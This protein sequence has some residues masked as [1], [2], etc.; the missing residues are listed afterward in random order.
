MSRFFAIGTFLLLFMSITTIHSHA[1]ANHQKQV[2]IIIDD[3]GGNVKGVNSFLSGDIPITA[4]VM[5]FQKYSTEQAQRA[6]EAGLEVIIHLP[7]EPKKGKASWLGPKGIKSGLSDHEIRSRVQQAIAD[8]PHAKGLNNH[9][10]SKIVEN[11]RIM[12][13]ILEVVKE[14]GLYVIDS[15]TSSASVIPKLA[16]ELGIPHATRHIF[17]DDTFSSRQHVNKQMTSLLKMAEKQ[18]KAIG[19]GHVGVKGQETFAGIS[20]ALPQFEQKNIEIVPASHL[21]DTEIDIDFEHF[22]N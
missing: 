8:V 12:R 11:E 3:F 13:I 20:L 22:W 4:A 6:H 2:A 15:G 21:L 10:G 18:K 14:H 9:M 17:L 1:F 19:I 16:D 7:M 5:P